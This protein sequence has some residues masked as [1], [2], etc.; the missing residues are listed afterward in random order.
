MTA[1]FDLG[2]NY[3]I[4]EDSNGDLVIRDGNGNTVLKHNNGTGKLTAPSQTVNSA[5]DVAVKDYV[6]SVAQGLDWQDSVIDE[7]ND[8][9]SNPNTGDRYLIDDNPT[10]DW[11]GE[12]NEIAEWDGSQ[13]VFFDPNDGWAVFLEDVDLLKVYDS[14]QA[15]WIAFGS[16]IDHGALAGLGDD[17]HTQYLL[18]DGSRNMSGSLDMGSNAITNASSV[19]TAAIDTDAG[20]SGYTYQ[21]VLSS[22][23]FG[24]WYQAPTDRD[25]WLACWVIASAASTQAQIII[26]INTSESQNSIYRD[27]A[28]LDTNNRNGW[29]LF[30]VPAGQHYRI[31]SAADTA[32]FTLDG[33]TELR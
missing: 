18:V 24:V 10:G 8:P 17:D 5:S 19:N 29:G 15:D 13:W 9:P 27:E 3:S 23:S 30:R 12:P 21:D 11:S 4:D 2:D 28:V 16:A 6:D 26:D 1:E 33:W 14:G 31:R 25:I 22:R 32:D 7:Q 20:G